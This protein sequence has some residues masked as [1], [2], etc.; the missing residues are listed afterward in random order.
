[1]AELLVLHLDRGTPDSTS[2]GIDVETGR[3][4]A[5]WDGKTVLIKKVKEGAIQAWCQQ[6]R[7]LIQT[8][9]RIVSANGH[10]GDAE[11]I[12]A[13][14]QKRQAL[15][16]E[17]RAVSSTRR[18]AAG[19]EHVEEIREALRSASSAAEA[20][21]LLRKHRDDEFLRIFLLCFQSSHASRL[22]SALPEFGRCCP[23]GATDGGKAE[24]RPKRQHVRR[25]DPKDRCLRSHWRVGH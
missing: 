6:H 18:P 8:G 12:L 20:V 5:G 17:I 1:M 14:C 13:E 23:C 15:R 3:Q 19:A 21:Q 9:D 25:S 16:L 24:A 11:R 4:S 7:R 10:T 2:L 22:V